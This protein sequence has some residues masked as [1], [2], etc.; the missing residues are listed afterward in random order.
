MNAAPRG[1]L[2]AK[3]VMVKNLITLR[4]ETDA[5]EAMRTL[6]RHHISG[7]PVVDE[8]GNY[9]GMFSERNAISFLLG[10]AYEQLPCTQVGAFMNTDRGCTIGEDADL[11]TIAQIFL[12]KDHRRLPVLRGTQLVGQISR[13][14]VLRA[15]LTLIDEHPH[16]AKVSLLYLSA[17]VE[18]DDAPFS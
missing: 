3:D 6:L 8:E 7:A 5:L 18:R 16:Q 1:T 11:L 14:D 2:L 15:A 10:L 12:N 4:A 13:R 9:L 17:L